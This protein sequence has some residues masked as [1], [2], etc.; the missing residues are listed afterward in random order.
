MIF[1]D[2]PNDTLTNLIFEGQAENHTAK[3]VHTALGL[4]GGYSAEEH[5]VPAMLLHQ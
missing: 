5:S 3:E 4:H 1:E 2:V